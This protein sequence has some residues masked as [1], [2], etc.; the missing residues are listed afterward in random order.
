MSYDTYGICMIFIRSI[1]YDIRTIHLR[2]KSY[3]VML[4]LQKIIWVLWHIYHP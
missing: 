2:Y 3:S 1:A 4:T